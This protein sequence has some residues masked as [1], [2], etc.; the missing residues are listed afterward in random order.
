LLK[1]R[2]ARIDFDQD[3]IAE[4]RY[5]LYAGQVV[6]ENEPFDHV[7]YA[8]GSSMIMPHRAV[9]RSVGEQAAPF[10]LQNTAVLRG[11]A[12]NIYSVIQPRI[13]YNE[14]ANEDDIY[15]QEHGGGIR[16]KGT[17]SPS[18]SIFPIEIPYIGDKA[19]QF[20]QFQFQRRADT[21]GTLLTSQGLQSDEFAQ[22]TATRFKGVES[23]GKGKVEMITRTIAETFFRQLYDGVI[24]MATHF[25]DTEQEIQVLGEPLIID[26]SA[27]KFDHVTDVKVGLGSGDEEQESSSVSAILNLVLQLK[28]SG[29]QLVDDQKIYNTIQDL[30]KSLGKSDTERHFNNPEKPEG[31][32]MA[33]NESMKAMIEDLTVQLESLQNPL[34]EAEEVKAEATLIKAQ[35]QNEVDLIKAQSDRELNMANL[36]NDSQQ[37]Q[38]KML[39]EME[40]LTAKIDKEDQD[41]ALEITKLELEHGTDIEGGL[42]TE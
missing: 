32:L 39:L 38:D 36:L 15:D 33:Q 16:I 8:I 21:T 17:A 28:Q 29:S 34:A 4:R 22:E 6:L 37:F 14:E 26:P 2:Y 40:K 31:L 1:T 9:G 27:W 20:L 23:Q 12:D 41:R 35:G 30:L 24:W 19:L 10:N 42:D 25:Q 7:P 13:A 5:I 3:G 11:M 18:S